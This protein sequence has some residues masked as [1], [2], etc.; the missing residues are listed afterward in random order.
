[1]PKERDMAKKAYKVKLEGWLMGQY[2]FEG[3]VVHMSDGEAQYE[4]HKVEA[5]EESRPAPRSRPAAVPV[6]KPAE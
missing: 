6:E 4:L 2:R 5:F 1:M 3:D